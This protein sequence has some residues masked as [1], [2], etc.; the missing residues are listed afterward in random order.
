M[1][2][3]KTEADDTTNYP[4][5]AL[6]NDH[7]YGTDIISADSRKNNCLQV[8]RDLET[9]V[10]VWGLNDK[11]QLGGLRG[12]KVIVVSFY[13]FICIE[14]FHFFFNLIYSNCFR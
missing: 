8:Q 7:D 1:G 4:F 5:L 9:K 14:Y 11:D 6:D 10:Y 12:S 2:R 13:S 3:R